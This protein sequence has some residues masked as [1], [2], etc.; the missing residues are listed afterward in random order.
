M[1]HFM[2]YC[3]SIIFL[4]AILFGCKDKPTGKSSANVWTEEQKRKYYTDSFYEA[5]N[6]FKMSRDSSTRF[7]KFMDEH[8]PDLK[9]A[10]K[11][12]PFTY[13]LE[14]PYIDTTQ[15][16]TAKH[17]FRITVSPCFRLPYCLIIE[18]KDKKSILTTKIANGMGCHYPGVLISTTRLRF[19]D[20]LYNEISDKLTL[21][22]FWNLGADTT[23]RGGFDGETWFLEAI[24]NGKYNIIRR[25]LP[26]HCGSGNTNQLGD[27]GAMLGKLGKLDNILAALGAPE[28]GLQPEVR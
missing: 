24:E 9:A 20:T 17:W 7:E 2:T 16:D 18:K 22:N 25:W 15:I 11:Y 12:D 13:S 1:H 27:I 8:Y 19:G 5:G 14:E 23:C 10:N 6:D 4:I 28:S 21:L 3:T 26:Q